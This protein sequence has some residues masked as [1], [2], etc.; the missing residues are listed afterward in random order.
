MNTM[1]AETLVFDL[2]PQGTDIN[3]SGKCSSGPIQSGWIC[4]LQKGNVEICIDVTSVNSQDSIEGTVSCF[5]NYKGDSFEGLSL[6]SPITFS[7]EY[8][9]GCSC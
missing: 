7:S 3:Y 6:N 4:T 2:R 1:T 5:K 9:Y 8:V